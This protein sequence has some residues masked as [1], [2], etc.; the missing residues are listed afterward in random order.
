MEQ[1]AVDLYNQ[2]YWYYT[3]KNDYPRDPM[4]GFALFQQAAQLGSSEAMNY[5]GLIHEEGKLTPKDLKA[6][7]QWYY[8]ALQVDP[9][10]ACAANNLGNAFLHGTGV[11]VNV[12]KA[13]KLLLHAEGLTREEKCAPYAKSCFGLGLIMMNHLKDYIKAYEYFKSAAYCEGIPAAWHNMGFLL[14][15]H[16]L[17]AGVNSAYMTRDEI[18]LERRKQAWAYY[19]EAAKKNFA[20]SMDALGRLDL[21]YQ[22]KA[23]ARQWF[24]KAA[25]LGYEPSQK[26]LK[27]LNSA[28]KASNLANGLW[29]LSNWL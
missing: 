17:P 11:A 12:D 29:D 3:G 16:L 13:Y 6:A 20:P 28:E 21:I 9:D 10:N 23:A 15:N 19:L 7:A 14:E 5:L 2:G 22:D 1:R 18:Q 26:R 4:K 24:L 27:T 8:K 25:Q